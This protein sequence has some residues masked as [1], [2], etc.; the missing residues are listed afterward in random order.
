MN[1][2][3]FSATARAAAPTTEAERWILARLG[4]TLAEVEAHFATYRFDLLAQSLY[5][6][7]WNEFCDWFLELAK[8]ALER[9]AM[10]PPRES[11]RHT[12]LFVLET[13][14]RALHPI[15]PFITEEIWQDVAPKLGIA[16]DYDFAA[17]YPRA[18][19]LPTADA[20][21]SARSSGSRPC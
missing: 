8:P 18:A 5:E 4:R 15:I 3:G 19:D 6:F 17:A 12:L 9:R 2:E 1:G 7:A 13:L 11:T 20:R 10:R 21:R 16:G 14:L